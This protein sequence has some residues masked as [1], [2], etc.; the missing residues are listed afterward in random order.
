[1]KSRVAWALALAS[2]CLV[3]GC[4][5]HSVANGGGSG[6]GGDSDTGTGESSTGEPAFDGVRFNTMVTFVAADGSLSMSSFTPFQ[7][8]TSWAVEVGT[9]AAREIFSGYYDPV[10]WF[11]FPGV[12]EGPYLLRRTYDAPW[13]SAL[14]LREIEADGMLR[15]GRST[16]L[17]NR[18]GTGLLSLTVSSMTALDEEDSFELYSRNVDAL[19][20]YPGYGE[21]PAALGSTS[22]DGWQIPW[23]AENIVEQLPVVDPVAGDDLWLTHLVAAPLV[24]EPPPD[25]PDDAWLMARSE[26]LVEVAALELDEAITDTVSADASGSFVPVAA[27]PV[28]LDLR[29]AQFHAA[30]R[31]ILGAQLDSVATRCW[32]RVVVAPG[33]DV[34]VDGM[35]PSLARVSVNNACQTVICDDL[36]PPPGDRVVELVVGNPFGSGTEMLEVGCSANG[37]VTHP[38]AHT[39][40][41]AEVELWF[42]RPLGEGGLVVPELGMPSDIRIGGEP[43]GVDDAL[44]GVGI[45]PTVSLSGPSL[46]TADYYELSVVQLKGAN[47]FGSPYL[48]GGLQT[49]ATTFTLPEG[50]LQPG[51][52]YRLQI[53]VHS[54]RRLGEGRAYYHAQH[55][56]KATS[57]VFTP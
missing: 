43:C 47:D 38:E 12:P 23:V 40:E 41:G 31:T 34:P 50:L 51:S 9:G 1:M 24:A 32:A 15:A 20:W 44:T 22:I 53:E 19:D 36:G 4:N 21:L 26:R 29:L 5:D 14:D 6:T 13:W 17:S 56:N 3:A 27:A 18:S 46:G 25:D 54:G 33:E 16:A 45:T 8:S 48:V 57:G 52:Y 42:T 2:S 49:T 10:G 30:L 28:S 37:Y 11:E 35:A 7:D 55:R 39:Q